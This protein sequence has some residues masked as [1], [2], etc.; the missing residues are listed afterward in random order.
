LGNLVPKWTAKQWILNVCG[1]F[2]LSF[3]LKGSTV[4]FTKKNQAF[5]QTTVNMSQHVVEMINKKH[6]ESKG[7]ALDFIRNEFTPSGLV[8]WNVGDGSNRMELPFA[9]FPPNDVTGLGGSAYESIGAK[10]YPVALIF[11]NF[12]HQNAHFSLL[13]T[14]EKGLLETFFR[15]IMETQGGTKYQLLMRLPLAE[16]I[17]L[18]Q[19]GQNWH[20]RL[21]TG[22]FDCVVKEASFKATQQKTNNVLTK[23]DCI[24]YY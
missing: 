20:I 21:P 24:T 9:T 6:S 2:G 14:G 19:F 7:Y 23:V 10:P 22:S 8:G 15:G 17:A 13:I 11:D 4:I 12:S 5:R 18:R 3:Q 1:Q 16:L